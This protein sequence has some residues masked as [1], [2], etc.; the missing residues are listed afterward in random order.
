MRWSQR[1]AAAIYRFMYGR[2]GND[3]LNN[4]LLFAGV[5]LSFISWIPYMGICWVLSMAVWMVV[6]FRTFSRNIDKRRQEQ[7]RF[8][9][10]TR[11]VKTLF[12]LRQKM[13]RE[14]R[15]HR[16]FRCRY[17][18]AV[19]RVQKGLG[20]VEVGCPRCKGKTKKKV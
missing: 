8:Q 4:T 3:T 9:E 18:K 11:G 2:Y 20:E 19:L 10:M 6:L 15:T 12:R 13:W 1:V 16:Y 7:Q 17:C 5:A 14:R